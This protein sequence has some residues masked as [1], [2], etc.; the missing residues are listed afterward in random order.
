MPL[1]RYGTITV[2]GEQ[3][4]ARSLLRAIVCQLAVFHGHDHVAVAAVVDA[5]TREEWDWLKWLPHHLHSQH[6]DAL[7]ASRLVYGE[8]G[9]ALSDATSPSGVP[10]RHLVVILDGGT[11]PG[12]DRPVADDGV[13]LIEVGST[14]NAVTATSRLCLDVTAD[15][16]TIDP[17]GDEEVTVARPDSLTRAQAI[18]CARRLAAYRTGLASADRSPPACGWLGL[19]R[20]EDLARIEPSKRW[21]CGGGR[22]LPVPIGVAEDGLPVHLDINE[23]A[24]AVMRPARVMCRRNRIRQVGVSADTGPGNDR[25]STLADV[26]NLILVDFKGGA[27]FLGLE[28][29]AARCRG[30]HQPGRTRQHLGRPDERQA[31]LGEMNRRQ[32]LLRRPRE[33]SRMSSNTSS[34]RSQA[35]SQSLRC[36]PVRH[37]R[38]VLRAT[39]PTSRLRRTVRRNRPARSV[40]RESTCCWPAND[41]TKDDCEDWRLTCRTGS[42]SRR[43]PPANLEPYW[44]YPMRT[45]CR[46]RR[47]RLTSRR[48]R[49]T[50]CGSRLRSFRDRMR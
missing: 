1:A 46:A 7:G 39:Q 44:V 50:W 33:T 6:T 47:A 35:R 15:A 5:G 28:R 32:E 43:S 18:M 40:A 30:H 16:L 13:T 21:A 8:V 26:L 20:I 49:M 9:Q 38:R 25:G 23:A 3:E 42:A 19:M 17:H 36:P 12:H 34:A 14:L 11:A 24:R 4:S 41:W 27:T 22:I 2:R 29:A 37:R 31:L 45:I 48:Q 10:P